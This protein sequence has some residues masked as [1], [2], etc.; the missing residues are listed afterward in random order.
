MGEIHGNPEI[1]GYIWILRVCQSQRLNGA[2]GIFTSNPAVRVSS[3]D[4][5]NMDMQ[6][7]GS[8]KSS[9]LIGFS[10]INHPFWGT[11]IFGNTHMQDYDWCRIHTRDTQNDGLRALR[12]KTPAAWSAN[13]SHF[14]LVY[15]SFVEGFSWRYLDISIWA[16]YNDVSRGHPKWWFNKGTSPNPLNSGLG[17]ILICPD[18]CG[19]SALFFCIVVFV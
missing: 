19:A 15:F 1:L 13:W 3:I 17:I 18:R 16:N 10:I 11:P 12:A 9:I 8:P 2:N 14:C 5:R 7:S 6:D 4:K